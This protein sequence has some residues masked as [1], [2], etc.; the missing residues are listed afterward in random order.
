M[1][2][3]VSTLRRRLL[4]AFPAAVAV[5]ALAL[6][7][8]GSVGYSEGGNR[9]AGKQ[10]FGE[11]CANC[12]ALAD[13]GSTSTIGPD[14]DFAF[15]QAREDGMTEDTFQQVV[16]SQIAYPTVDPPTDGPGMPADL[17]T[18]SDADDV[19]RYVASVAGL[20][21]ENGG[22]GGDDGGGGGGATDGKS[23]FASSGC[24]GCHT[25]ADAGSSGTV[26]PNLDEA[27]PTKELAVDRV[28]NGRG[29]MPAFGGDLTD[30][31]IDAVASYVSDS[32][33]G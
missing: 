17:V 10:L 2:T 19:A 33:G 32:A 27:K 5:A 24:G 15:K 7:G 12:H 9:D 30:A 13:A 8:C 21:V 28:T 31:Q 6:A 26:G 22:G 23:L 14:L 3:P 1:S 4:L 20:P 16:R 25:L 11:K 18:G 29:G